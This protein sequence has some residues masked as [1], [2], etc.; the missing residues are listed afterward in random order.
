MTEMEQPSIDPV[1]DGEPAEPPAWP[2]VVGIISIVLGSL[3]S[4]CGLC[5][6]VWFFAAPAFMKMAEQQFGPPPQV[7]FPT[8]AQTGITVLGTFLSVLLLVAGIATVRRRPSGRTLHLV[9]APIEIVM[10]LVGAWLG[11]Q[12]QTAIQKWVQENP[13]DKWAQ[14]QQGGGAA[15]IVVLVLMTL[16]AVGWCVFLIVWFGAMKRR[17]EVGAPD[18]TV[19]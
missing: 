12:Q 1:L 8:A 5:G 2:K 17:P 11:W 3:W 13:T 6:S 10:S 15:G 7:M 19:I 4:L 16:I 14:Q 9:Y 18:D